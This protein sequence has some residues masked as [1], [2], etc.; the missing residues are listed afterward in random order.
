MIVRMKKLTILLTESKRREIL[1]KLRKLGTVHIKHVKKPSADEIHSLEETLSEIKNATSVLDRYHVHSDTEKINWDLSEIHDNAK[2]ITS[3][4][5]ERENAIRDL[6]HVE[7]QMEWFKPWG[8]FNIDDLKV[9]EEKRVFVKLYRVPKKVFKKLG[10]R[11]DIHIIKDEKQ[12]VY[13]A[14][15]S[16]DLK[17]ELPFEEIKPIKESFEDLYA[18]R[19]A[20]TKRIEEIDSLLR[21]KA[22]GVESLKGSLPTFEKKHTFLNVMHGMQEEEGFSYLQGFCPEN[23]TKDVI[24]LSKSQEFGYLIEDP[25]DPMETPTLIKNPK[26]INIINPV[27]KFMN[28]VPGYE[29]FDISLWFLLFFSLFFAM[30]IGDAGYGILFAILTFFASRKMKKAPREPFRLMYVLSFATIVWGAI[31]GTWFGAEK[32]AQIPFFNSM[33]I[34]RIDSFVNG[35]Q[36]FMIYIC[37]II[38]VI[39][40]SIAHIVIALRIINTVKALAEIGWVLTIWGL[41]FTAGTLI[42]G[43]PFPG[44]AG[45]LFIGGALLILLFSNPQK[46][47]FKGIATT[48]VNLPL[49][50]ISS[51]SDVVSY[52]RLFAVGYAS[53]VVASIFNNMAL[54]IGFNSILA[55]FGAA[56]IMF[57]GHALNIILG[58]MAVIVHGIRLNMLEF[59][60]QM[61]M[62]WSGKEYEPFRENEGHI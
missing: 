12:Y 24:A 47:I 2:E 57:F 43:N 56:L 46:N 18:K 26:W 41:F 21:V 7:K 42:L 53:V 29:E 14:K 28:T 52:L 13:I 3:I 11:K 33:V 54:E 44:F 34:G 45:Y 15:I 49:K 37:F 22:R 55:G 40:L 50:I 51:F 30:L 9:L 48:L 17:E 58:L 38:G 8:A 62:E 59:S 39:Q 31:T 23:K 4:S 32:I 36:N 60:G 35:N 1:E 6:E 25:S 10:E 27:F 61:G 5:A 19:E 16:D 20:L